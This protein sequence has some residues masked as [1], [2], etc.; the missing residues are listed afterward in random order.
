[1]TKYPFKGLQCAMDK[2]G[3]KGKNGVD[4]H[5]GLVGK[6]RTL[7]THKHNFAIF[8]QTVNAIENLLA[9]FNVQPKIGMNQSLS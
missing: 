9:A 2:K 5:F 7:K 4:L 8:S 1:M 3:S 6:L